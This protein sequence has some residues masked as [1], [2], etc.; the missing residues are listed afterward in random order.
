MKPAPALHRSRLLWLALPGLLFLL[1]AWLNALTNFSSIGITLGDHILDI[2]DEGRSLHLQA[3]TYAPGHWTAP[4]F[5]YDHYTLPARALPAEAQPLFPQAL[6]HAHRISSGHVFHS[7]RIAWWLI[8]LLYLALLLATLLWWQRRKTRLITHA[9]A[10][11]S[12]QGEP[13]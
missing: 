12:E 6:H 4:G 10:P 1:W 8:I 2:S 7:L 9:P 13:I 3:I 11:P 5:Y